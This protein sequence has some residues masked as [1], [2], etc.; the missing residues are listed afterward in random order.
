[1]SV[2]AD[3]TVPTAAFA[4]A[5][6]LPAAPTMTVEFERI[7]THSRAVVMPFMWVTGPEFEQ[8]DH[9][10]AA[11][12]TVESATVTDAFP[13]TRL[14]KMRW[15][16]DIAQTVDDL[17]NDVG[18]LLEAKGQNDEWQLKVRFESREHLATFQNHFFEPGQVRLNEIL[19]PDEPHSGEFNITEK[20]REA[21][22]AAFEA[23]YYE[24]PRAVT[25]TE[26]ADRFGL[27][28][29]AFSAR[30]RRGVATLIE[31]TIAR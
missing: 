14:Y 31:N 3:F 23:G 1:M 12:P 24:S 20:Q 25:A 2:I 11:D 28:Q 21:L 30:L 4:L 10:L 9:A 19:T 8:F 18:T 5:E 16:G 26:L 13:H 6:T 17:L 29:Q 7:A 22:L 15:V 27:S